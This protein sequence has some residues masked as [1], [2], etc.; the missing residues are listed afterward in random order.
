MSLRPR[1][2]PEY[3]APMPQTIGQILVPYW[4]SSR[5]NLPPEDRMA[6]L[7]DV[8]AKLSKKPIAVD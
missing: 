2:E 6:A 1:D 7:M 3:A 4:A 5:A 8:G